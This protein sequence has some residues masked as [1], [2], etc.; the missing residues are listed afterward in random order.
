[1]TCRMNVTKDVII[2]IP[3]IYTS[4]FSSFG[5]HLFCLLFLSSNSQLSISVLQELPS[6]NNSLPFHHTFI[7]KAYLCYPCRIKDLRKWTVPPSQNKYILFIY[8]VLSNNQLSQFYCLPV[9]HV[10]SC[11]FFYSFLPVLHNHISTEESI[12]S[13]LIAASCLDFLISLSPY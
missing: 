9:I 13:P 3:F 7:M 11:C 4:Y 8:L 10:F 1:M 12:I 2:S 5:Y 6:C